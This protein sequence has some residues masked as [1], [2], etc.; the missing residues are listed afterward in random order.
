MERSTYGWAGFVAARACRTPTE[1]AAYSRR[2]GAVITLARALA[3]SDLHF[4]NVV[5]A[6]DRPV[7]V[8][9]ECVAHPSFRVADHVAHRWATSLGRYSVMQSGLLPDPSVVD[10]WA[11]DMSGLTRNREDESSMSRARWDGLGTEAIRLERAPD[12]LSDVF[13]DRDPLDMVDLPELLAGMRLAHRAIARHG[14]GIDLDRLRFTR[15][16]PQGTGKYASI[17]GHALAPESLCDGLRFSITL[18]AVAEQATQPDALD[19]RLALADP[20]RAS[21]EQLDIPLVKAACDSTAVSIGEHVVADVLETDGR[22]VVRAGLAMFNPRDRWLQEDIARIS[23]ETRLGAG[24]SSTSAPLLADNALDVCSA[25]GNRLCE[26]AIEWRDGTIRWLNASPG[27]FGVS[28][29][30]TGDGLY[31]GRAGI[32]VFL[33][34]LARTRDDERAADFARRALRPIRHVESADLAGGAAGIAF[35]LATVGALLDD[36]ALSDQGA[37]LLLDSVTEEPIDTADVIGGRAGIV[38]ASASVAKTTGS[39]SVARLAVTQARLLRSE[40]RELRARGGHHAIHA[41]RLGTAHGITGISL[42][43]ARALALFRDSDLEEWLQELVTLENERIAGRE[44]IAARISSDGQR[45]PDVGWCWGTA[46]FVVS[47]SVVA[48][49]LGSDE[50]RRYIDTAHTITAERRASTARLCCGSAGQLEAL[51]PSDDEYVT[52]LDSLVRRLW[53]LSA[54]NGIDLPVRRLVPRRGRRGVRTAPRRV[55]RAGF[56]RYSRLTLSHQPITE[57]STCHGRGD[58]EGVRRKAA[59]GAGGSRQALPAASNPGSRLRD[60]ADDRRGAR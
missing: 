29:C 6:G 13:R 27:T 41:L 30:I 11:N 33:A 43:V 23:L 42:A 31:D 34:A 21:L 45:A 12:A 3:V 35:A 37:Q 10:R 32:A 55:E 36:A 59:L 52:L 22:S 24:D 54:R 39:D 40:W 26:Q 8:D 4:E 53:P 46:G 50:A 16:V 58:V 56:R 18:D 17:M 25:I 60:Q 44:G 38:L 2:A 19:W 9:L 49:V 15:V 28:P 51:E 47:R 7:L 1:L 14:L 20:E 57:R 5:P 48:S